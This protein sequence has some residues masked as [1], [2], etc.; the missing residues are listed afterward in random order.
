MPSTEVTNA[1]LIRYLQIIRAASVELER[2]I[3]LASDMQYERSQSSRIERNAPDRHVS[4][5]PPDPTG[6]TVADPA[7]AQVRAVMQRLE[8]RLRDGAVTTQG[9]VVALETSM[10]RWEGTAP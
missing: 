5:R 8:R 7:R 10:S 9:L 1:R 6:E 3:P 2:L 4:S